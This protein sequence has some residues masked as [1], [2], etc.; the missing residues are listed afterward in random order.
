MFISYQHHIFHTNLAFLAILGLGR[1]GSH[2][3]PEK[4]AD[5]L[6]EAL[7]TAKKGD[8]GAEPKLSEPKEGNCWGRGSPQEHTKCGE[9]CHTI[10]D[11]SISNNHGKFDG[12]LPSKPKGMNLRNLGGIFSNFRCE[13]CLE[14]C[15]GSGDFQVKAAF[16]WRYQHFGKMPSDVRSQPLECPP[17]DH[18]QR[19]LPHL[20]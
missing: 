9:E 4:V 18:N 2:H 12:K 5:L 6:D 20:A 8:D 14:G 10:L 3:F 13:C 19:N 11:E 1:C 15:D 16:F 7:E 17:F